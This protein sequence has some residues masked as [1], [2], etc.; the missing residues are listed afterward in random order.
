MR[1]AA[2]NTGISLKSEQIQQVC[3]SYQVLV[4]RKV[5]GMDYPFSMYGLACAAIPLFPFA[6]Q[7]L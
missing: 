2:C 5:R 7:Q 6:A 4:E 1:F 3:S